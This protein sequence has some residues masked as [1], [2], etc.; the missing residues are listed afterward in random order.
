MKFPC[1][2][3]ASPC[4]PWMGADRV[5]AKE[6]AEVAGRVDRLLKKTSA[7]AISCVTPDPVNDADVVAAVAREATAERTDRGAELAKAAVPR[8]PTGTSRRCRSIR[9][10]RG[11]DRVHVKDFARVRMRRRPCRRRR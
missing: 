4:A 11:P 2:E 1:C 8:C 10:P 5:H 6:V 7:G 3:A 9:R